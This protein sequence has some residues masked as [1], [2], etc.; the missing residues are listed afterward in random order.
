MG[1]LDHSTNNIIVDAVLTDHGRQKLAGTGNLGIT[2]YAF[3]D[4]EIDYTIIRKYGTVIGKE[5]IEKNTPV[6]EAS[7]KAST[8]YYLLNSN[9][10]ALDITSLPTLAVT[11]SNASI[12]GTTES[13]VT[14]TYSKSSDQS[15]YDLDS[16]GSIE[17]WLKY[18]KR[19]LTNKNGGQQDVPSGLTD[20]SAPTVFEYYSI[21]SETSPGANNVEGTATFSKNPDGS[22]LTSILTNN[23]TAVPITAIVIGS[24]LRKTGYITTDYST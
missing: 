15:W 17:I 20:P 5:K 21:A 7:T 14:V 13:T 1:Y 3:A 8:Q 2:Q 19:F 10:S 12:T 22:S 9:A 18:D 4:N 16:Y 24:G 23:S 6:M 11:I